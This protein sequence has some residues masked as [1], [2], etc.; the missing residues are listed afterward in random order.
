[1]DVLFHGLAMAAQISAFSAS[2]LNRSAPL[3]E[4]LSMRPSSAATPRTCTAELTS[5]AGLRNTSA[6]DIWL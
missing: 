2:P 1:M 4:V 6:I 3:L 5:Q